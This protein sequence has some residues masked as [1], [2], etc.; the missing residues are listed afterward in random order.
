MFAEYVEKI[1]VT[2][3]N[4]MLSYKINFPKFYQCPFNVRPFLKFTKSFSIAISF[5]QFNVW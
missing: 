4:V 1:M 5:K 3:F 2:K